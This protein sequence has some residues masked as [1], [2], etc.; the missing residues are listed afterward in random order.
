MKCQLVAVAEPGQQRSPLLQSH[1][2]RHIISSDD[3]AS[4]CQILE[5]HRFR[6]RRNRYQC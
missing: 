4:F 3:A 6:N 5:L 1:D 2:P